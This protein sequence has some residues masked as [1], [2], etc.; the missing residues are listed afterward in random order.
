MSVQFCNFNNS[1]K[2]KDSEL[3]LTLF[4][5][6]STKRLNSTK[7]LADYKDDNIVFVYSIQ[8]DK[9]TTKCKNIYKIH[10]KAEVLDITRYGKVWLRLHGHIYEWELDYNYRTTIVTNHIPGVIINFIILLNFI[11]KLL[12]LQANIS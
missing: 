8:R 6:V 9:Q 10:E 12:K 7:K 2:D 11:L 5:N 4:C 1:E 3:E